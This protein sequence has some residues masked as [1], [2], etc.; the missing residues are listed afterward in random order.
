M[1]PANHDRDRD[2]TIPP[3]IKDHKRRSITNK[4]TGETVTWSTYGYETD[5][6][7]AAAVLVCKPGGGPPLHY[8]TTY[9]ERFEALDGAG[10]GVLLGKD[11]HSLDTLRLKPGEAADIPVGTIHR[12]FNDGDTDVTFKGF[13][14]PAHAGFERSLYILF[15]LNNDGLADPETGM[16]RS[17]LHTALIGEMSDMKFPGFRGGL[18]N[19]VGGLLAAYARWTGVE[20]ELLKKYWD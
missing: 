15:G 18:M 8:H 2:R 16:P 17:L 11:L 13:V 9:A 6:K 10:I 4:N 3:G 5:G 12:F 19:H 14:R 20:E 7:E 1:S